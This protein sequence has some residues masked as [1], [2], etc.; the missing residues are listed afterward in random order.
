MKNSPAKPTK[1][2][3]RR[4]RLGAAAIEFAC[5]LPFLV[6]F[7]MGSVEV[8][9]GVMV[10]HVLEEAARAGCRVA[11]FESSSAAD[12]Q[13]IVGTAM[14]AANLSSANYTVTIDPP[15]PQGLQAFQP[16][17]V[18]IEMNF[19][20]VSW[21]PTTFLKGKSVGGVCVMPA[22]GDGVSDP[23]KKAPS[24]KKNDGG[25]KDD[26]DDKKNKKDDKDDKKDDKDDK[27]KS[28]KGKKGKKDDKDDKDGKDDK[29]KSKKGKK[30]K[31]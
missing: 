4:A 31:K 12:V 23:T 2:R 15:N 21:I 13:S 27:G 29:G 6:L 16:V 19:A 1:A 25:D 18:S 24:G 9:R 3:Y 28:K 17:T 14:D 5:V 22:E 11:V 30:G 7:L 20:D 8:G 10:K 26:K